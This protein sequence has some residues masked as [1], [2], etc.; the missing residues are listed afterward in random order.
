MFAIYW[1]KQLKH[2]CLQISLFFQLSGKLCFFLEALATHTVESKRCGLKRPGASR[3]VC[4]IPFAM[5]PNKL[6]TPMVEK[7]AP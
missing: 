7:T 2:P 4:G 1:L 3:I 6:A 5:K